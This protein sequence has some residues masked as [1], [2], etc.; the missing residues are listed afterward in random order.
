MSILQTL[1]EKTASVS[2]GSYV[3]GMI[4]IGIICLTRS[5]GF[6]Q[7]LEWWTFDTFLRL[8]PAASIDERV[9][10]VTIEEEDFQRYGNSIPDQALAELLQTLGQYQP[11]AI[12]IDFFRDS[13]VEPGYQQLVEAFRAG[14]QYLWR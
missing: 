6:L 11:R 13:P 9:V 14:S 2:P 8:R 4:V 12:G 7:G 10:V 5:L 3:P 1:K